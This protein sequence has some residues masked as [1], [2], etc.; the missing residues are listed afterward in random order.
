MLQAIKLS[1]TACIFRP[2]WPR[3][4]LKLRQQL[5]LA[6]R[7]DHKVDAAHI[8]I[9]LLK[10]ISSGVKTVPSGLQTRRGTLAWLHRLKARHGVWDNGEAL[11]KAWP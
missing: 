10:V 3:R 5:A 11:E 4:Q 1:T 8:S 9:V 2:G 7:S 6:L